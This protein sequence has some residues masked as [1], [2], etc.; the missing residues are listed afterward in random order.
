M[1]ILVTGGAGFIGR[2]VCMNL[3]NKGHKVI[4]YDYQRPEIKDVI[5]YS[6]CIQDRLKLWEAIEK[7]DAVIHL[8]GVL[9]TAETIDNPFLSI[10]VNITGS[11]NVFE[12][13]RKFEKRGVYIAVGNPFMNNSYSITKTAAERLALM[14]NKEHGTKIAI[15][16]GLNVY[17][18]YQK[19][20]PVRKV[21]PNFCLPA[22]C[23]KPIIIY[24]SGNQVMDFIYAADAAEVLSRALLDDHNVYDKIFEAGSGQRTTINEIAE[25]VVKI[26]DSK[27]EIIHEPMRQGEISDSVVVADTKTLEPLRLKP[28]D[29]VSMESGLKMT[30][31]YYKR[32]FPSYQ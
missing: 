29:F 23:D 11:T 17:G 9:G 3:I 31:E 13:C 18:P 6:G 14:Y 12:A 24:G 20:K 2:Y 4:V 32:N 10:D 28:S 5:F 25:M 27:S 19:A 30:I 7:A 26:S 1:N 16:R 21:I 8:T 15:V 22:I